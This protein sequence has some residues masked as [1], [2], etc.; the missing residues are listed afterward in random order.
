MQTTTSKYTPAKIQ[1]RLRTTED[2]LPILRQTCRSIL[3]RTADE[4][5]SA[6]DIS[7]IIM[8]DQSLLAKVIKLANSAMYLTRTPVT[9][10]IQAV[11]TVGFDVIRA[12]AIGAEFVE[13][14]EKRGG[15][16][17][18]LKCLLARALVSAT[19]ALEVGEAIRYPK[20]E[21]LFTSTMLYS[22][23]DLVFANYFPEIYRELEQV[24]NSEPDRLASLE[25]DL[26]GKPLR[27]L[28]ATMAKQWGLPS[29][30]TS[31]IE[32]KPNLSTHSWE[33]PQQRLEGLVYGVNELSRCL[34]SPPTKPIQ[35][36][37]RRILKH[38][39][40]GLELP[41]PTLETI[42]IR[43]FRKAAQFSDTVKIEKDFFVPD[44]SWGTVR[45]P[46]P[47]IPFIKAIWKA[48]DVEGYVSA[49]N[50]GNLSETASSASTSGSR[51]PPETDLLE[52][53]QEFSLRALSTTDP[54]RILNWAAEGL[55]HEGKFERVVLTVLAP[56]HGMIEPRVGYGEHVHDL[57]P[58]FRTPFN[59]HHI[60][61]RL[62][63]HCEP[64]RMDNLR[65]DIDIG[66][67]PQ[68]FL[69]KWGEG[70]CLFG[71]LFAKAQPVG[72]LVADHGISKRPI[73]QSDYATFVMVLAQ[74]NANLARLSF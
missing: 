33:G 73:S 22:L 69:Q 36:A 74:I 1:E 26:L 45:P 34:L 3:D 39:S 19:M 63:K 29:N 57:L 49:A 38:I 12:V 68:E 46:S 13:A 20:T 27:S 25:V 60:V 17:R 44:V 71:P 9:T 62:S 37:L 4:A 7:D 48:S 31:V 66:Q 16:S 30:I 53:L 11:T 28:A 51:R 54:N 32:A 18:D 43:A 72:L 56:A 64:M 47:H 14:A 52:W 23:G 59:S 10:A 2:E 40:T 8:R 24:R 6:S 67:V 5:S 61:A 42:T 50:R 41:M 21:H 35:D 55:H 15:N 70:P 58:L 65:T